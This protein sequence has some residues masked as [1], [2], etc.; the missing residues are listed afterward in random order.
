M[1]EEERRFKAALAGL[2]AGIAGFEDV[3]AELVPIQERLG[4]GIPTMPREMA[5]IIERGGKAIAS[6]KT[7]LGV[8]NTLAAQED[9]EE[10]PQSSVA[11]PTE[12][13]KPSSTAGE[14]EA[15]PS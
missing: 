11:A 1:H 12:N 13:P 15:P 4:K 2:K 10:Q 9:N 8:I 3:M 7:G 5:A 6:A 14:T